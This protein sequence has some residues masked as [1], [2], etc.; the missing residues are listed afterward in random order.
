LLC[1][2]CDVALTYHGDGHN[3]LCHICG[4]HGTPPVACPACHNADVVYRGLGTKTLI[5]QV[6][7]L[8][9]EYR[10]ARFDSDNLAGERLHELYKRLH[11]GEIDLIVGTQLL[12]KGLDLPKLGLVGIVSAETSLA[13]PDYTSEERAFQLLYQV[14]G[15]VGRGHSQGRVVIQSYDPQSVVIKAALQRNYQSL[16]RHVLAERQQFRFPPF[17]Y[18]MKLTCR[19]ASPAGAETAAEKLKAELVKQ[20]LAVEVI[21][22]APSFY[23]RRGANHYWQLVV[24]SKQRGLLLELAKLVPAG[25]S[26]DLDPADLL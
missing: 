2:H 20:R 9:P 15:R 6:S 1:P 8:F 26:I 19:R 10:I 14:I 12:A 23:A 21:G 22:P 18:L 17:A 7:K 24:K 16:Y 25:W 13:L 11:A 5:D 3:V 4:Y